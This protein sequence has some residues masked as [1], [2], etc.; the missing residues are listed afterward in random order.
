[1]GD[2]PG[3]DVNDNDSDNTRNRARFWLQAVKYF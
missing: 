1:M 2:N 3:R